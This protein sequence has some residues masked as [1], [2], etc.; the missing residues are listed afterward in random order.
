[1]LGHL[2]ITGMGVMALISGIVVLV[3]LNKNKIKH[4]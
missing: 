2:I 4:N 1:M 3:M